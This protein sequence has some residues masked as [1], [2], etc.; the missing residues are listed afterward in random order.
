MKFLG[1]IRERLTNGR[2]D[3]SHYKYRKALSMYTNF[4]P[5]GTTQDIDDVRV[6]KQ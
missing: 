4:S 3:G 5:G 6:T 1:S 2:I